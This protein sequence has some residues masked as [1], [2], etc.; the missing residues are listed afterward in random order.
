MLAASPG[1]PGRTSSYSIHSKAQHHFRGQ[2][3]SF[4]DFSLTAWMLFKNPQGKKK[5][6]WFISVLHSVLQIRG[7]KARLSFPN[8]DSDLEV[9]LSWC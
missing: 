1:I 4:P 7:Q 2:G 6:L 8:E 9:D 3:Q 5:C